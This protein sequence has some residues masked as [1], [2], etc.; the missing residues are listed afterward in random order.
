MIVEV[1]RLT[2]SCAAETVWSL[3][4]SVTFYV[5]GAAGEQGARRLHCCRTRR[6]PEAPKIVILFRFV[7]SLERQ[8]TSFISAVFRARVH[9]FCGQISTSSWT[10]ANHVNRLVCVLLIVFEEKGGHPHF[11]YAKKVI[12]SSL[13]V[14][15]V[16]RHFCTAGWARKRKKRRT[17]T[18][19][20][21][22]HRT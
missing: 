11:F 20:R 7:C 5:C 15:R 8:N 17:G 18:L 16:L 3:V 22:A 4:Q 14:Y 10:S 12:T 21:T 9:F 2:V 13:S 6:P 19:A 1:D